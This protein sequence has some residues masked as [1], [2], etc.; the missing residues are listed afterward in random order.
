M[1]VESAV[2]DMVARSM[3]KSIVSLLT[4]VDTDTHDRTYHIPYGK[5]ITEK[6]ESAI[7]SACEQA[8]QKGAKRLKFKVSPGNH[9]D[10][11]RALRHILDSCPDIDCMVDANGMFDPENTQHLKMLEEIDGLGLLTIEEPVSRAGKI[12]GLDAHRLLSSVMELRTPITIDDAVK[13]SH[14]AEVALTEDLADIVNLKPGRVGSFTKCIEIAN[15]A[16]RMGKEVMV[17]GMFEATPGRMM[18]LTLAAYCI[19]QGFRIPGDLSLPQERL[20]DDLVHPALYL[21]NNNDV[22]FTPDQGWGYSI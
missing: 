19:Q 2:L 17:G 15:Y 6:Q 5:S 1:T 20:I 14:D 22:V 21:D 11:M 18:T 4:G 7:I 9:P 10:L 16:K 13:T 8:V 3:G 12:S